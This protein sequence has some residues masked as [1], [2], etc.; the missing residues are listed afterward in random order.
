MSE[1]EI[2]QLRKEF[3]FYKRE[4]EKLEERVSEIEEQAKKRNR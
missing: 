3:E 2:T 4:I 1:E